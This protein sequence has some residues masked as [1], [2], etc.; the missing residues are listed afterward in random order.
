MV[1]EKSSGSGLAAK[2][3]APERLM[4]VEPPVQGSSSGERTTSRT[5]SA[6]PMVT[7]ER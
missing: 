5:I 7:M 6:V 2:K 4:P 3:S 1:Q